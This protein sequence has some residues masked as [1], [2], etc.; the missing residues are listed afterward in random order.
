[1]KVAGADSIG[2]SLLDG[3]ATVVH[4][5]HMLT[6]LGL[7]T[8]IEDCGFAATLIVEAKK[9]D[10][11][12]A[13]LIV[14]GMTCASCVATVENVM[15]ALDG[16]IAASANL[17]HGTA[18]VQYAPETVH[19][20]DLVE[21]LEDAGFNASLASAGK[22][23]MQTGAERQARE[24]R[25]HKRDFLISLCLTVP[26][27]LINMIIPRVSD[28]AKASLETEITHGLNVKDLV[29]FILASPVE[30]Y[31]GRRFHVGAA[32]ALRNGRANMDVLVSGGTLIAYVASIVL[33][34]VMMATKMTTSSTWN[35]NCTIAGNSTDDVTMLNGTTF[36]HVHRRAAGM[37]A[38]GEESTVGESGS[39]SSNSTSGDGAGCYET[40]ET[41]FMAMVYFDMVAM[42]ITFICFGKFLESHAKGKTSDALFKLLDLQAKTTLV[43][44]MDEDGKVTG[45]E[46]EIDTAL[47]KLGD[48]VKV[49]P[50]TTVSADGDIVAGSSSLDESMVTGESMPVDKA[51]GG[52]VIGG[53]LNVGA[54]PLFIKVTKIGTDSMLAQIVKLI[55]DAQNSKA[56]IQAYADKISTVFVPAVF[57]IAL[58]V[59]VVW[60]SVAFTV[61]PEDWLPAGTS[62]FMFA[63]LF[64]I[65][66]VVI[67]CPCALG[68]ATPTAVM[69]GTGLGA[70]EGILIKGGD[71]LEMAHKIQ[72]IIFDKTGT[73]TYGRPLVTDV[74]AVSTL[75]VDRI[76]EVVGRAESSS[77]HPLGK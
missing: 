54:S 24:I 77:E 4:D 46:K 55:S 20:R 28:S 40:E 72:A 31:I 25:S 42:L 75:S 76:V 65:S 15:L 3:K 37:D 29:S 11:A 56:P 44:T 14:D 64:F 71:A 45:S 38:F 74:I 9:G 50:G 70:K 1:M 62:R 57:G 73:L 32:V 53:T 69:V 60:V 48:I 13:D 36:S 16:V 61:M 35:P 27:F 33:V 10:M 19:I 66:T 21:L 2:V 58:L 39:G 22:D 34:I 17:L 49:L 41:M 6:V 51:V 47:L 30:L 52:T 63:L 8:V 59:F 67:A 18:M 23:P 7:K 5:V 26:V 68:L 12:T 43:V